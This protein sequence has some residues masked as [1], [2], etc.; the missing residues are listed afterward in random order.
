MKPTPT[1]SANSNPTFATC[2]L[3]QG[4]QARIRYR[5]FPRDGILFV[6]AEGNIYTHLIDDLELTQP[7][8][9]PD[10]WVH[11]LAVAALSMPNLFQGESPSDGWG[12]SYASTWPLY[13]QWQC[14]DGVCRRLCSKR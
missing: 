2:F 14:E 13:L 5:R 8:I 9:A 3:A 1:T 12:S 7:R 10:M 4:L 11:A 6:L